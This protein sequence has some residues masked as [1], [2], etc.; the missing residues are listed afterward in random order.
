MRAKAKNRGA[1]IIKFRKILAM[2][3]LTEGSRET[4]SFALALAKEYGA[5]VVL[6]HV[7][8]L[9][10]PEEEL[11]MPRERMLTLLRR[12]AE[13][14]LHQLVQL[15]GPQVPVRIVISEGNPINA[16]AQTA[17]SLASDLVVT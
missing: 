3:S 13:M 10:M 5:E 6:L 15:A 4:L 16:I 2:I 7:L 17:K 9:D 1:F 14:E 11:G 8:K 12:D